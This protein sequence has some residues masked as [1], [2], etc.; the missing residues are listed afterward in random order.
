MNTTEFGDVLEKQIYDYLSALIAADLYWVK[1]D[2]CKIFWKKGYY[3][4]QRKDKITFDVAIEVWLPR[5]SEY[6]LLILVECKRYTTRP[7]PVG[8]IE[9]FFQKVQQVSSGNR[10]AILASN[11]AFD[12]GTRTFAA[13]NGIA[14]LRYID[15]SEA[16][17]ELHRPPSLGPE[18]AS[19][20]ETE[21]INEALSLQHFTRQA[22]DLYIQFGDLRTNSFWDFTRT[23]ICSGG[24][25]QA[26]MRALENPRARPKNQVPF[27]EDSRLEELALAI[28]DD[29]G[30]RSGEVSLATIC[31]MEERRSGLIVHLNASPL[32]GHDGA[33][34][35]GKI[36]F[37]P[38]EIKIFKQESF[39]AGRERFTLAHELAHYFLGHSAFITGEYCD[40]GDFKFG[41]SSRLLGPEIARLEYQ[42]NVFAS[43]LL[44]PKRPFIGD[45]ARITLEHDIKNK[46]FGPLY[47]DDQPCNCEH[48]YLV[49]DALMKIY[50][51]SRAAVG[52][53]L[54]TLRLLRD[55][56]SSNSTRSASSFRVLAGDSFSND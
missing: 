21:S 20:T 13:S 53:R 36:S 16:K 39:N 1:K 42:A 5:A 11:A 24:M 30:Y 41:R 47:V 51:A 43:C 56:R 15:P 48:F 6:S 37:S 12:R 23:L 33:V 34:A 52:L 55:V 46:I 2:Q 10:K 50:G 49:T 7:V 3:S 8:D 38:L 17:W 31:T 26:E 35:L 22:M 14:L 44:M 4:S 54:E 9:Q 27:I 29:I 45:F 18:S 25:S 28:L 32:A 19:N 40:E